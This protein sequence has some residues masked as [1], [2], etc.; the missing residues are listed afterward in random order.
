MQEKVT[1][2]TFPWTFFGKD[3]DEV[4]NQIKSNR[5][6]AMETYR[7]LVEAGEL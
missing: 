5:E 3:H 2:Y 7:K 6:A 1:G 4:G